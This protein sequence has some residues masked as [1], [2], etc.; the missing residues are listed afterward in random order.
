MKEAGGDGKVG[1]VQPLVVQC[2][3][4]KH[5]WVPRQ[6]NPVQCPNHKCR[7]LKPLKEEGR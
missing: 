3:Y 6:A 1:G 4:C 5:K 7:R 2:R